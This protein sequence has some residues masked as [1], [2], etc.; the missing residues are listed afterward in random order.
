VENIFDVAIIGGGIVGTAVAY[1]LAHRA[2]SVVLLEKEPDVCHGVSKA[3][4]GIVHGGFHYSATTTL[5]GRLELRGNQAFDRLQR[6]LGFPFQRCGILVVAFA[7]EQLATLEKLHAQGVANGVPGIELCDAERTLQLEPKLNPP[8]FGSLYA[9]QG[10]VVEPYRLVFSLMS[11]ACLNGV[12]LRRRFEVVASRNLG[13]SWEMTAADGR[14][15]RARYVI[16]A[17]GLYADVV[18]SLFG[19]EEF[20]ITPRKGE[21][22]LLDRMSQAR[23][24]KVIF[25]VPSAHTKGV[26]V[27]PTAGGTTMIG[28]TAE[29]VEDKADRTTTAKNKERIFG[30]ARKM[31]SGVSERDLVT[32]FSGSRPVIEGKEDFFL[33]ISAKAPR[34]LQAAGIQSPGLT[35][36][37]AIAEYLEQL[38][39]EAGLPIKDKPSPFLPWRSTP[40]LRDLAPQEAD[41]LHATDNPAW[42]NVVCR[43]ERVS[44]AEIRAAIRQGHDSLEGVKLATRAGMGRCQGGF[45][46]LKILRLIADELGISLEEAIR[47][48]SNGKAQVSILGGKEK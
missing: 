45:C 9:P 7:E 21:E 38:L 5:K 17:A 37:P 19:A 36:S 6:E 13:E 48:E 47:R 31:V 1:R 32:S 8:V 23:P 3:N 41:R 29:I 30:L 25:P 24:S 22:Y 11:A 2:L 39:A 18:S 20:Q 16:N 10:G 15:V 28:P 34:F 4:S 12:E 35:A 33:A 42:T 14:T 27:I 46:G 26:L 43:C 44:E 40:T